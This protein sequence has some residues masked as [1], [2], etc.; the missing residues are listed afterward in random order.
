MNI[1]SRERSQAGWLVTIEV[2]NAYTTGESRFDRVFVS[3]SAVRGKTPDQVRQAVKDALDDDPLAAV[4]GEMVAAPTQTKDL[5]EDRMIERYDR[6][7]R[8]KNTHAEAVARTIGAAKITALKN[9]MDA[10]WAAYMNAINDWLA[11][12]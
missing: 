7:Q 2:P 4:L 5:L 6:W 10:T 8:W 1:V 11:A 9:R 12:P 3:D